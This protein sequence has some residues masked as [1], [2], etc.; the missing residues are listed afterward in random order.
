MTTQKSRKSIKR[1]GRKTKLKINS[2]EILKDGRTS[3][4]L[5]D[6]IIIV[7]ETDNNKNIKKLH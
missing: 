1:D 3:I 6:N 4:G 2:T 5:S 7:L